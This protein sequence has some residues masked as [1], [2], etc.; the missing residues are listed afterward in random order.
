[1]EEAVE[2]EMT[3][4][5]AVQFQ[6]LIEECLA[7]MRQT[8]ERIDREQAEIEQLKFETRAM[9]NQ[10]EATLNVETVL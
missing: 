8:I 3:K 4:A 10:I 2:L 1:M 6:A 7:K 5:E 9:L